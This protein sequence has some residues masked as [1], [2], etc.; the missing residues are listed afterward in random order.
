MRIKEDETSSQ[1]AVKKHDI[2]LIVTYG[3]VF[4]SRLSSSICR[5]CFANEV[6]AQ[7]CPLG[8]YFCVVDLPVL[9]AWVQTNASIRLLNQSMETLEV[10]GFVH[11]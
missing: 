10:P 6:L 3:H 5:G 7:P 9:L 4:G 8:N 11:L 1:A 2:M